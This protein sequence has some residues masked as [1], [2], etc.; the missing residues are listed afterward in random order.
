MA[1]VSDVE[2]LEL[3]ARAGVPVPRFARAGSAK[4][5]G[6][7]AEALGYPVVMKILSTDIEHKS[8]VGGVVVSLGGR[9]AVVAAYAKMMADVGRA[10]P[11]ARLDGVIILKMVPPGRE[12]IVG[13]VQDA[14]FGPV[15]MFGLGG[16]LTELVKDVS[17]RAIPLTEPDARELIAETRAP[18]YL[19]ALRGR[20]P[21]DTEALVGLILAVSRFV[22][23]HPEVDQL[24]LNPVIVGP[25]GAVA[26]D[27]RMLVR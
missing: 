21:A 10:A 2:V 6:R 14:T 17:F 16:V 23:A 11:A 27:A 18:Q 13:V 12:V 15:V 26:V 20:P 3:L 8:D 19:G 25:T 24:D 4:E 1:R 22:E 9:E 5:A 7:A